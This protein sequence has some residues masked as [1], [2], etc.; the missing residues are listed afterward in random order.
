M[1]GGLPVL[2][3]FADAGK[4]REATIPYMGAIHSRAAQ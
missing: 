1:F 2:Q 3:I 4:L